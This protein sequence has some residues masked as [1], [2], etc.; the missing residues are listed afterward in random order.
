[1]KQTVAALTDVKGGH[2]FSGAAVQAIAHAA[3]NTLAENMETL[4]DAR[5]PQRQFLA[6]TLAAMAHGLASDVAGEAP[7]KKLLSTDQLLELTQTVF[8][9]VARHPERLLGV[10]PQ[11]PRG[12]ALAQI[13]G[14]VAGTLGDDPTRLVNGATF[15]ELVRTSLAVALKNRDNLLDLT[16]SDPKTNLL[17]NVLDGV[18]RAALGDGDHR[19]LLDR[20]V[21]VDVASRVLRVASANVGALRAGDSKA[22]ESTLRSVLQ[23]ASGT[24]QDQ[25]NGE[26]L[27]AVVEGLLRGVLVNGLQVEDSQAAAAAAGAILRAA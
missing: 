6:E 4:I 27:P 5:N 23:L 8:R 10:K 18:A 15:L 12:T 20:D 26:N 3:L 14:S 13:L 22:I 21:F 25:I 19:G 11:D 9:E 24:L 17:H 2:L 16:S 7:V 1:V